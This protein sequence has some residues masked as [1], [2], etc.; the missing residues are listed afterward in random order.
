MRE[1]PGGR[2]GLRPGLRGRRPADPIVSAWHALHTTGQPRSGDPGGACELATD[3]F[4][5]FA[6]KAAQTKN[7]GIVRELRKM[8]LR[9]VNFHLQ[10]RP[11][12]VRGC[13]Y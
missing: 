1:A 10:D 9:A 12:S 8:W 4:Y 5:L 13:G 3:E 11:S 7:P 2:S 6:G